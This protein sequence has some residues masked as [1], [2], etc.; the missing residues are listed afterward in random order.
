M[1]IDI[2][3]VTAGIGGEVLLIR[4]SE[5]TAVYDAGMAY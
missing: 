1:T 5:K 2:Q 4:G 3:R